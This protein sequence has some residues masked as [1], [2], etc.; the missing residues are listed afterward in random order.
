MQALK[1]FRE[2]DKDKTGL[3]PFADAIKVLVLDDSSAE[4]RAQNEMLDFCQFLLLYASNAPNTNPKMGS[5]PQTSALFSVGSLQE[6]TI[7]NLVETINQVEHILLF[8][9]WYTT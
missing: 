4:L 9:T 5:A 7:A 1:S 3:V 2:L 8:Y 6:V